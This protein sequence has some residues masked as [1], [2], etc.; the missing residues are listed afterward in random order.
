M[1]CIFL[2]R[3]RFSLI[4]DDP[5]GM[6]PAAKTRLLHTQSRLILVYSYDYF[7]ELPMPMPVTVTVF[8][9]TL[10]RN[11]KQAVDGLGSDGMGAFFIIA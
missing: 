11:R 5:T 1:T 3:T 2:P 6:H 10:D 7:C 9:P 8:E 4:T